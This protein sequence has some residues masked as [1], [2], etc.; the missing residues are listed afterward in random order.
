MPGTLVGLFGPYVD[1]NH[2]NIKSFRN[3]VNIGADLRSPVRAVCGGQIVYADWF[4][5]YGNIVII[6]HGEHYY[7]LSAQLEEPFKKSGDTVGAGEVIG[8]VGDT[9]TLIGPGLYFEIRHHGKPMDPVIWF[10]R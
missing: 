9:G 5:G 1:E 10:K 8:T 2:Y 7:T 3:G 6:D 4:R